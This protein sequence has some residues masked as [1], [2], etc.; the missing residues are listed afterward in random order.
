MTCKS[1]SRGVDLPPLDF[2]LVPFV[3]LPDE[4]A[5]DDSPEAWAAWDKAKESQSEGEPA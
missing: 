2:Q 5:F 1:S 4:V 3:P